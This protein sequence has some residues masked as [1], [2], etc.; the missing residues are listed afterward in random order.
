MSKEHIEHSMRQKTKVKLTPGSFSDI[1]F[2]LALSIGSLIL[3]QRQ[4]Q[5]TLSFVVNIALFGF[6][7]AII[8]MVWLSFSSTIRYLSTE[9]PFVL[10]LNLL[11]FFGVVLEPYI[12]YMLV[13]S[14]GQLLSVVSDVF[15]LNIGL[16]FFVLGTLSVIVAKEARFH[17]PNYHS[18][19]LQTLRKMIYPRYILA[20]LFSLSIFPVFWVSTPL[21]NL[22]ILLWASSL[23]VFLIY[24]M[25]VSFIDPTKKVSEVT[26]KL[27]E[28]EQRVFD[29][30]DERWVFI[31]EPTPDSLSS[32]ENIKIIRDEGGEKE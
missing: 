26:N 30:I 14:T 31:N 3:V 16:M 4:V 13:T 2:G 12:F 8:S 5:D 27:K 10:V 15:A 23:G 18:K 25:T 11:L 29:P 32:Q 9:V 22:R 28:P 17:H 21:G 20:A 24:H 19:D 7:F 1:I 6:S